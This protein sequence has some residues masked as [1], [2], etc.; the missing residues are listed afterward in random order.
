MNQCRHEPKSTIKLNHTLLSNPY[1]TLLP[2]RIRMSTPSTQPH[3]QPH[4][5][6]LL[7]FLLYTNYFIDTRHTIRLHSTTSILLILF[8]DHHHHQ[9][10][11]QKHHRITADLTSNAS[12]ST[13]SF[14]FSMLRLHSSLA[15][16]STFFHFI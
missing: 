5:I 1:F 3:P 9:N 2:I 7:L 15:I 11:H 6:P 13:T 4:H 12:R 16:P 8:H 10:R 14:S